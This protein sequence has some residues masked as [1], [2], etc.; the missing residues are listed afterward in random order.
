M[1]TVYVRVSKEN[2]PRIL[3]NKSPDLFYVRLRKEMRYVT[4]VPLFFFLLFI[5][6]LIV[7]HK[8]NVTISS[9]LENGQVLWTVLLPYRYLARTNDIL[10]EE[11]ETRGTK[12]G[13]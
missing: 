11:V 10:V 13:E 6:V 9:T 12:L 1:V 2:K 7:L 5:Y 8:L 4:N 3:R